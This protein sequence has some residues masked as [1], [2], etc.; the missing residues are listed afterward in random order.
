T[1]LKEFRSF[2]NPGAFDYVRYQ[3]EKGLQAQAYL[4]DETFLVALPPERGSFLSALSSLRRCI[5]RFRQKTLFWFKE[6]LDRDSASFYAALILGYQN[7]MDRDRL[8]LINRTG[9][10]HLLSVSGLHLGLVSVFVF[11]LVRLMLRFTHPDVLNRISDRQIAVWPAL[12]CAVTYGFLAGFGVPPIWRS[13]LMLA[14]C[15]GAAFWCRSTDSLTTVAFAAFVI[16]LADPNS[17]GQIS[18]QLSFACVLSIILIYPKLKR[19]GISRLR[20]APDRQTAWCKILHLFEDAFRVTIAVNI[21][22]L[23]LSVYYF[24][25][26]SLSGFLANIVLVP[27]IGF[28]ILPWGLIS[29]AVFSISE[30]LAY[31]FIIAGKYLLWGCLRLMEW[32]GSFSWSY[33]WAGS[34][35]PASLLAL[36]A[37]IIAAFIPIPRRMRLAGLAAVAALFCGAAVWSG[38]S[39]GNAPVMQVDVIDVGQGTS[40]LIRFPSGETMLVDGG[41]FP[42]DSFD[43]G[44]MVL[45]PFLW[46]EGIRRIGHVVLSHDHP[47]HRNGLRFILGNFDTGSFWTDGSGTIGGRGKKGSM[48]LDEIALRRG[49]P[50]RAFPALRKEAHV[51]G[52]RVRVIHPD[53]G[54]HEDTARDLNSTSMVIEI[55]FGETAVVLPGDIGRDVERQI[56]SRFDAKKRVLLVSPH[57]G[58]EHS[59]C[60]ELLDTLRPQA[61]VFSCGYENRYGFPAQTVLKRCADRQLPAYRTD[62]QGAVHAVSDGSGWT[63]TTEADRRGHASLFFR[64]SPR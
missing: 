53:R 40:T 20:P 49:I 25:G 33:F 31:P 47:D 17:I 54:P 43:I 10:N 48:S 2:R 52:S 28:V 35:S 58:S 1:T 12:A 4:K 63:I 9:L 38:Y 22:V 29:V 30:H 46:H 3:A 51:G 13:V 15:F 11:S 5:E 7:F 37:V 62:L 21:L 16:L 41:G 34:L 14:V 55:A 18:F 50:L 44:R 26:V 39:G 59:N 36:Y 60:E 32:F 57:H 64:G 45:A 6:T 24:H 27:L 19:F 56:L 23:P 42:D 8:E 61:I